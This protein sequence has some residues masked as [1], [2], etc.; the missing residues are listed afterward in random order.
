MPETEKNYSKLYDHDRLIGLLRTEAIMNES[1]P[2]AMSDTELVLLAQGAAGSNLPVPEAVFVTTES[3]ANDLVL[4]ANA[5][6]MA[7]GGITAFTEAYKHL[8][9]M[10][11]KKQSL[12]RKPK[13]LI[14]LVN[15]RLEVELVNV[16]FNEKDEII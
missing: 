6:I 4:Q 15:N 10:W 13:S 2:S 7:N 9:S 8:E 1:D 5:V 16:A 12:L 3:E 11:F 14:E